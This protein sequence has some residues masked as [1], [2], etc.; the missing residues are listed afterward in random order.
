MNSAVQKS[1]YLR[2]VWIRCLLLV[3]TGVIA[4]GLALIFAPELA[5]EGFSMLVYASPGNIDSF[6]QEQVRYISL[7]HAV[8]GGVMVGWGVALFYATKTLLARRVP[9]GW[10]LVAWSLVAWY[11]PDTA[12]SLLTGFWQNG[13]L[14]SVFLLIFAVPLWHTRGI[15]LSDPK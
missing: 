13:L 11:V 5:R 3:E 15:R 14:N 10:Y 12:Y 6:G 4:F 2:A 7:T 9:Q 8:I 1:P